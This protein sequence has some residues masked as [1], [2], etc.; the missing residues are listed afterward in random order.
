MAHNTYMAAGLRLRPVT[1]SSRLGRGWASRQITQIM[2]PIQRT[3]SPLRVTAMRPQARRQA[4]QRASVPLP[5]QRPTPHLS[6][7]S[8]RGGLYNGLQRGAGD[9][10]RTLSLQKGLAS[11]PAAA[12]PI[13]VRSQLQRCHTMLCGV[14]GVA[15][16][17]C[18]RCGLASPFQHTMSEMTFHRVVQRSC[19]RGELACKGVP[20]GLPCIEIYCC[21]AEGDVQTCCLKRPRHA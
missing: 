20:Q 13:G 11:R 12:A 1:G 4:G 15:G 9:L 7:A 14:H 16:V 10:L 19:S 17:C 6:G 18:L 5:R 21:A 2:R 3:S 8:S